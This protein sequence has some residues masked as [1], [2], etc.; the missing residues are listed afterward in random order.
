MIGP[1]S[2]SP[3]APSS[4]HCLTHTAGLWASMFD[5]SK[6]R[7]DAS[8]EEVPHLSHEENGGSAMGLSSPLNV[9]R[10]VPQQ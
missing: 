1:G 5:G 7:E 10:G 3:S 8:C 2:T 4:G 9:Q 6:L